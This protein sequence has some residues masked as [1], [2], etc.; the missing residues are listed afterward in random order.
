MLFNL[1]IKLNNINNIVNLTPTSNKLK[2]YQLMCGTI[3][4]LKGKTNKHT[5]LKFY[6][7]MAAPLLLYENVS[8]VM[9]KKKIKIEF[10]G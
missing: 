2:K 3:R 4:T 9:T 10:K 8:C 5:Q 7:V 6:K 1:T